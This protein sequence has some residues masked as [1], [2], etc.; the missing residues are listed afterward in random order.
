LL[1]DIF[2]DAKTR[3]GTFDPWVMVGG[4]NDKQDTTELMSETWE[5][6]HFCARTSPLLQRPSDTSSSLVY[7]AF[8]RSCNEYSG[9]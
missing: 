7:L 4:E 8:T 6:P 1:R 2:V 9:G 5:T 3:F